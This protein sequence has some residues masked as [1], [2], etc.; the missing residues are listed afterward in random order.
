[1]SCISQTLG[2]SATISK[3]VETETHVGSHSG[4]APDRRPLFFRSRDLDRIDLDPRVAVG[5]L[6]DGDESVMRA[7]AHGV[8]LEEPGTGQPGPLCVG[9][10]NRVALNLRL[11]LFLRENYL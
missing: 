2:G 6:R 7:D 10:E 3:H 1:M 8:D 4:R 11:D 5:G 9:F